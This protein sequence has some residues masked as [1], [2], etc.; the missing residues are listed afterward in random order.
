MKELKF[1]PNRYISKNLY[2]QLDHTDLGL[3]G[4]GP[5]YIKISNN[6]KFFIH[7]IFI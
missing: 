6:L 7:F 1:F 4:S 3:S 5:F 2:Y